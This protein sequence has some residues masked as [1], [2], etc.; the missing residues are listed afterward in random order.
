MRTALTQI[1]VQRLTVSEARGFVELP[2]A[3][4]IGIVS[5]FCCYWGVTRL[6]QNLG[7]DDA[8]DVFGIHGIGGIVGALLTGVFAKHA[9]GGASG[10]LERTFP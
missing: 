2:G 5:A 1:G 3:F 9:I 8:L 6:K 4:F 10:F 7:Y